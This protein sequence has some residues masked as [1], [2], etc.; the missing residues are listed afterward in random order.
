MWQSQAELMQSCHDLSYNIKS[1]DYM[2]ERMTIIWPTITQ[3]ATQ[4]IDH[5]TFLT[6]P[7]FQMNFNS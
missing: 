6:N 1:N 5:P 4:F 2:P 7:G 3:F